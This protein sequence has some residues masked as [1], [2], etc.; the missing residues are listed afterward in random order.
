MSKICPSCNQ[1]VDNELVFC[2]FCG[3]FVGDAPTNETKPIDTKKMIIGLSVLVAVAVTMFFIFAFDL[4]GL[5]KAADTELVGRGQKL[6][7]MGLTPVRVSDKWGYAD[8][9]G[10]LRISAQFENAFPFAENVNGLALV[11]TTDTAHLDYGTYEQEE[12][13][14][15]VYGYINEKGKFVIDADFSDAES[16]SISGYA[17]TNGINYVNS[18]GKTL[19]KKEYSFISDFTETGYCYAVFDT[20]SD[21]Y[22]EGELIYISTTKAYQYQN[23]YYIFGRDLKEKFKFSDKN[24]EGVIAVFDDYFVC[25]K[26]TEGHE[27]EVI[28][29]RKFA[30]ASY[31]DGKPVTEFYDRIY[32][33]NGFY[34]L[35]SYDEKSYLY[36]A[37]IYDRDL[38]KLSDSY[39]T[40]SNFES[41]DSGLVL[42]KKV[43]TRYVKVLLNDNLEELCEENARVRILRGFDKS[44][45]ACVKE[46]G[47]Y[48]AY[49]AEGKQF[50]V[51]YPFGKM[52]SGL[53]PFLADDGRIGYINANGEI[54]LDAQ[55]IAVSEFSADGYATVFV[56]GSYK[57]IDIRGKIIIDGLSYA[58]NLVYGNGLDLKW[59]GNRSFDDGIKLMFDDGVI[60]VA[61][62]MLGIDKYDVFDRD[63]DYRLYN[64]DGTAISSEKDIVSRYDSQHFGGALVAEVVKDT[65]NSWYEYK[66]IGKDG[67]VKSESGLIS[68]EA[69]DENGIICA[70]EHLSTDLSACIYGL[71]KNKSYTYSNS[72]YYTAK[73]NG[74]YL[75]IGL[76]HVAEVKDKQMQRIAVFPCNTEAEIMNGKVI[77]YRNVS[78]SF[79][80]VTEDSLSPYMKFHVF[81][82]YN[83]RNI[84]EFDDTDNFI[85]EKDVFFT[86]NGFIFCDNHEFL[87][88]DILLSPDGKEIAIGYSVYDD[89]YPDVVLLKKQID[90]GYSRYTYV[91]R[92]GNKSEE[93]FSA[94]AFGSDGYAVVK[95]NDGKFYL[96]DSWFNE[97]SALDTEL[98]GFSNGLSP[99]IDGETG[100]I[101]YKDINGNTIIKAQFFAASD[102]SYD[103]YAVAKDEYGNAYI[104][105]KKGNTVIAADGFEG[106]ESARHINDDEL[107]IYSRYSFENGSDYYDGL[108]WEEEKDKLF[109]YG[110]APVG[111]KSQK[112]LADVY[113]NLVYGPYM[114]VSEIQVLPDGTPYFTT[115][116]YKKN[117][118]IV[119]IDGKPINLID[120][121]DGRLTVLD[122]G[123]ILIGAV[124]GSYV[125][126]KDYNVI[127]DK[128]NNATYK[129]GYIC[130][131]YELL[132]ENANPAKTPV[133]GGDVPYGYDL[134]F[135]GN[136]EVVWPDFVL[137]NGNGQ[138]VLEKKCYDESD[139]VGFAHYGKTTFIC[140]CDNN[141]A[142]LYS[143]TKDGGLR[144]LTDAVMSDLP[145][146]DKL[147]YYV[148]RLYS[149]RDQYI[150]GSIYIIKSELIGSKYDLS[151]GYF[152]YD[153]E[154]DTLTV[155]KGYLTLGGAIV[156]TIVPDYCGYVIKK[157]GITD[158]YCYYNE[159]GDEQL[160]NNFRFCQPF[161]KDGYASVTIKY[162]QTGEHKDAI[163]DKYGNVIYNC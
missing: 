59:Y 77:F 20:K 7:S 152:V 143:Y 88:D 57:I 154:T 79:D 71:T 140:S 136:S 28:S 102:F 125:L 8:K 87:K 82:Y 137:K 150:Y 55:Y 83:G 33:S 115:L 96:I 94:S 118:Q 36:K 161:S 157:D 81:D 50:T 103:G 89:S 147:E 74:Y 65:L 98:K 64:M 6:F 18:M 160:S 23:E 114:N 120:N 144:V 92:F 76:S 108:S 21:G 27:S 86:E 61:D 111:I 45:V 78:Y 141:N 128:L 123:N 116:D 91:D 24:G 109:K 99:F 93:Y 17:K 112:Y 66:I 22:E 148:D 47:Q 158:F 138:T 46:N 127:S 106:M 134:F 159:Q 39:Y 5:N 70:K 117:R 63:Y 85:P 25:F 132:D 151:Y 13:Q 60:S 12:F 122:N 31:D 11:A 155:E 9:N 26:Y 124:D 135:L 43:G 162:K 104:I 145:D 139:T 110:L 19:F 97:V 84:A 48:S 38:N 4:F 146:K 126:D 10:E 153:I 131:Y 51:S 58:L 67:N 42:Y 1:E 107:F 3:A 142:T 35:C 62:D 69:P 101:G 44:G 56:D 100:Y 37:E 16:F 14:E 133:G 30:L 40:D 2:N 95:K 41:Y 15:V 52:N 119:G 105:D 90:G 113:G 149:V 75:G 29:P 34:I 156:Y 32:Q 68:S 80:W 54:V 53:A 121:F 72:Y 129:H 49:N 163:I 130:L 73:D